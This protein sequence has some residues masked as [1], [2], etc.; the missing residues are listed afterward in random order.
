M[1]IGAC[2]L[3]LHLHGVRSLKEKRSIIKSVIAQLKK[4]FNASVA[5]VDLHDVWQTA[6]I[7]ISVT[8]TNALHAEAMLENIAHWLERNRPDLE[9]VS[10]YIETI[11]L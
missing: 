10:E 6:C 8:S 5:E 2:K 1:T 11:T 9:I 7:G 4:K 3:D